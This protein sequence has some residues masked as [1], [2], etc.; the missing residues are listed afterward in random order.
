[1]GRGP[2]KDKATM[3]MKIAEKTRKY[4]T[5]D[6]PNA[7]NMAINEPGLF[8]QRYEP[9]VIIDEIQYAPNLMQYIKLYNC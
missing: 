2:A 9:P 8:L 1:M 4:V 7:R 3:L 5:L 6:D